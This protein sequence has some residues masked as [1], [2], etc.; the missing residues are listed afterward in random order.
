MTRIIGNRNALAFE[1][2]PLTPTWERRYAAE[3]AAWAALSIWVSGVNLCE[4]SEDGTDQIQSGVNVPLGPF[5]D[6]FVRSWAYLRFEERPRMFAASELPHENLDQWGGALPPS[7]LDE[8]QWLETREVWWGRHF[9][10]AGAEGALLPNL[11]VARSHDSLVCEWSPTRVLLPGAP[12]WLREGGV[13]I[14][15]WAAAEEAVAGFV[16]FVAEWLREEGLAEA[17]AWARRTD[18]VREVEAD[19]ELTLELFTCHTAEEL[20]GLFGGRVGAALR[21]SLGLDEHD[22]D[23]SSSPV[24]QALRDLPPSL[25][26]AVAAPL[27]WLRDHTSGA[28]GGRLW[29]L[30]AAAADAAREAGAAVDAGYAS[31]NVVRRYLGLDGE[32]LLDVERVCQNL[33]VRCDEFDGAAEAGH[34]LAGA[35][36]GLGAAAVILKSDRMDADWARR[37]EWARALGHILLDTF[38]GRAVG[39]ASSPYCLGDRRRRSGAFAAELLLPQDAIARVTGGV[40]DAGARPDLFAEIMRRFGTGARTTANHLF[41]HRFLSS[42]AVRDDLIDQFAT[43]QR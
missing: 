21:R 16:A 42:S 19:R 1:L 6:W 36:E 4:H 8:D 7:G 13:C 39:A 12:R 5:A 32:P 38:R 9:A 41:N 2:R 30:R 35:R 28:A 23:P 11:A 27:E 24:T 37:F 29:A 34:M 40:L 14:V 20:S 26:T 43:P 25:P 15:P 10:L 3:Q 18:P 33:G 31:A 22:Q 17:Y